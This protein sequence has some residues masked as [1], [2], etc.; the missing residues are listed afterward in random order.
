MSL[1]RRLWGPTRDA[2]PAPAAPPPQSLPRDDTPP[3][4]PADALLSRARAQLRGEGARAYARQ[5]AL[6]DARQL[7]SLGETGHARTLLSEALAE[8]GSHELRV[9]LVE[10][11]LAR[12]E[13]EPARGL[14]ELLAREA[15]H[16]HR[17]HLDL[18]QLAED[19]GEL[20]QARRHYERALARR[21]ADAVSREKARRTR[22]RLE[23]DAGLP[24]EAWQSISRLWGETAA[25]D[26]YVVV[27]EV[28]RGGA[29]TLFRAREKATGRTVALKVFHPRGDPALRAERI[30]QEALTAARHAGPGV[31]GVLDVTPERDLMVMPFVAGG[32][33]RARLS[34]GPLPDAEAMQACARLAETLAAVHAAGGVHLDLKPSNVLLDE[35]GRPLLADFGAAG[36]ALMGQVAGTPP[37]MA[38]ELTSL[39][40]G[41]ARA[42]VFAWGVLLRECLVGTPSPDPGPLTRDSRAWHRRAGALVRAAVREDPARRPTAAAMADAAR[43]LWLQAGG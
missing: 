20:A 36:A 35:L 43:A 19:E 25:G 4:T 39:G 3:A 13:R 24:P 10:V 21:P 22:A 18:G 16:A 7:V 15:A 1:W 33:L 30:R 42:D 5:F 41:D 9:L 8:G 29:A 31:V 6:Q 37:Y 14:L 17:A 23:G 2:V 38:P 27:E 32:S 11:L 40:A 34:C 12:G 26:R 28:G